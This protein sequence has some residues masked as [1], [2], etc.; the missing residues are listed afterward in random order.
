MAGAKNFYHKSELRI[1]N[2]NKALGALVLKTQKGFTQTSANINAVRLATKSRAVTTSR[3]T[4]FT[5]EDISGVTSR[6][7]R[8]EQEITRSRAAEGDGVG[9]NNSGFQSRNEANAWLELHAPKNQ[10]GFIV[11]FHTIMEHIH[12][13]ITSMDSLASLGKLYKLRLKTMSEIVAMTSFEVQSP[14]FLTSSGAH[15]VVDSEASYFSHIVSYA[16]WND[17]LEGY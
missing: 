9:F 6:V 4:S 2:L 16:K 7:T 17:P 13:Q 14:R 5:L 10:F 3:G 12:Q 1:D 11:D 8:L 15:A